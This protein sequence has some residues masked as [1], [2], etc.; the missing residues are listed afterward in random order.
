MEEHKDELTEFLQEEFRKSAE[1]EEENIRNDTGLFM[2][3]GMKESLRAKI[4]EQI[5]EIQQ[6]QAVAQ[7]S[8]EDRKALEL[9]RKIMQEE[10]NTDVPAKKVVRRKKGWRLYVGLAAVLVLVMAV[11]LTSIGG[12]ERIVRFMKQAVGEREVEKVNSSEDNLTIVEHDE[13]VAYEEI[14][15]VFGTMPVKVVNG[16]EGIRFDRMELDTKMQIAEVLYQ[17][18][19]STVVYFINASYKNSSWGVD[20][21]DKLIDSYTKEVENCE[22]KIKVYE[23]LNSKKTRC[24]ASFQYNGLEYFLIGTMSVEEFDA[25]VNNLFFLN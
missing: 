9:G 1:K 25:I 13:E 21:E 15:K 18:K 8:D 10:K 2:P 6:E 14:N 19:N 4:D 3:E 7:L 16:P 22:I 12:P 24:S 23:V 5:L 11:G 20:V 17:Y